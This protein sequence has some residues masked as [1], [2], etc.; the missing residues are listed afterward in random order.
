MPS[1]GKTHGGGRMNTQL[2][3]ETTLSMSNEWVRSRCIS[4]SIM[5]LNLLGLFTHRYI[6]SEVDLGKLLGFCI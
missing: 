5:Q 4:I 2:C 6:E 1:R 3:L